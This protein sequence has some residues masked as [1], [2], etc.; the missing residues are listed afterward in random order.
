[1]LPV[2]TLLLAGVGQYAS[3]ICLDLM[4]EGRISNRAFCSFQKEVA[5]K[6]VGILRG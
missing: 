1:V 3:M 5:R 2:T 6:W 4:Q